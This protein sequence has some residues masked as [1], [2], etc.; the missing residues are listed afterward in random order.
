[1]LNLTF[2]FS[3]CPL[4]SQYLTGEV[5]CRVRA[6][7]MVISISDVLAARPKASSSRRNAANFVIMRKDTERKKSV[8][9]CDMVQALN[10]EG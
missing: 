8:L 2:G 5:S 4:A 6:Y 9:I 3:V 1:M 10:P 7:C